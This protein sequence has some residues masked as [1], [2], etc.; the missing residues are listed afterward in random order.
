MTDTSSSTDSTE[1]NQLP[2]DQAE[3]PAG[4]R[5]SFRRAAMD[6]LRGSGR[7]VKVA[8]LIAA[9]VIIGGAYAVGGPPDNTH[10]TPPP[11]LLSVQR[12][13][14][15]GGAAATAGPAMVASDGT[16]GNWAAPGTPT[17]TKGQSVTESSSY[18]APAAD[19]AQIVKTGQMTLEVTNLND[20]LDQAQ[21]AIAGMGGLVD[22]S[23][24][25]GTGDEAVASMTFRFPV[26][27]WDAALPALRKIGSKVLNE[28]TGSTDVTSQVV[29]L[30]ARLANLRT[31]EAAL[32][33]IM[34]RATAIPDVIAVELQL[35]QTQG[36]IEQLTAQRDHL[37]DRA[38]M[39]TLT[40]TFQM[41]SKTVTT[42][43]TQDWTLGNQID[44]AGAALVR[45]GQGLATMAVWIAIVILP[46]GLATLLL[47]GLVKVTRWIFGR[48]GS[49]S[50][51]TGA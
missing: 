35:S 27:K 6:R 42:Q 2:Q 4:S 11:D 24:R 16:G 30:D 31:T 50:A 48:G 13:P 28:Q 25:S 39:S 23:N 29:D 49:R 37:K 17:D 26:A 3:T 18:A 32:Q 8:A 36:Q 20:A 46:L 44:Q 14:Q 5:P 43:A 12:A 9:A 21:A 45:I 10:S 41:P 19:T 7:F 47:L 38:A 34:A 40:V 1:P 22:Q 15:P 33:A 51:A